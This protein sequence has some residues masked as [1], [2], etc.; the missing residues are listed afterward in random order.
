MLFSINQ[1][2]LWHAFSISLHTAFDG[3][4]RELARSFEH[5]WKP[6]LS[7]SR[8]NKVEP[9]MPKKRYADLNQLIELAN[10]YHPWPEDDRPDEQVDLTALVEWP[11]TQLSLSL[12]ETME[13][14]SAGG[15]FVRE[16]LKP[17]WSDGKDLLGKHSRYDVALVRTD[18]PVLPFNN[19]RVLHRT[20]KTLRAIL[21]A[22]ATAPSFSN[23]IEGADL[24]RDFLLPELSNSD[25]L[26]RLRAC[27]VC[28]RL[29]LAIPKNRKT[30][31]KGCSAVQR[32]KK[33]RRDNP[34]Y[35]SSDKR[36]QRK[37]RRQKKQRARIAK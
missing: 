12:E 10:L 1:F 21:I 23:V 25:N 34:G 17:C 33:F 9:F 27:P 32:A 4:L 11:G 13:A 35:Y 29:Y 14:E 30:C 6:Y 22:I 20:A 28:T 7:I 5:D 19:P 8:E 3:M 31:S 15:T 16:Y 18:G 26:S 36:K 37:E 2:L 24:L